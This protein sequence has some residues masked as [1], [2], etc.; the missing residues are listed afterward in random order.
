MTAEVQ[1]ARLAA[2]LWECDRHEA[3]L[4]EALADWRRAPAESSAAPEQ[5]SG[6]RRLTDQILYRFT[7]SPSCRM[8]SASDWCRPG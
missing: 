3:A 5:D 1:G 6:L 2:V 8:R 7:D 4:A